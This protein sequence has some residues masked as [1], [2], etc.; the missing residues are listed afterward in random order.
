MKMQ[1]IVQ[2]YEN[3]ITVEVHADK[4]EI[5]TWRMY[6]ANFAPYKLYDEDFIWEVSLQKAIDLPTEI[7][8]NDFVMTTEYAMTFADF[9]KIMQRARVG[10]TCLIH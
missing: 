10:I 5:Q 7:L 3:D 6:M 9:A 1:S 2:R 8:Y 4:I